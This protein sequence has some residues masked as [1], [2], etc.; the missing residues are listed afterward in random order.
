MS[1]ITK[2][3]SNKVNAAG[4]IASVIMKSAIFL[5]GG[6]FF[7]FSVNFKAAP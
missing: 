7:I 5:R 4:T 3:Q 6:S 1:Q 2:V